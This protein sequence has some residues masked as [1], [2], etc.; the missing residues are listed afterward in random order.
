VEKG[1]EMI[2]KI[3]ITGIR[4]EV[5][6]ELKKYLTKKISKLD[7]FAP[8]QARKNISASVNL[9]ERKTKTDRNQ[10]EVIIHLPDRQITA[11]EATINMFAAVDIV[12]TKLKSQLKK[13]KATHGGDKQDH[14]GVLRR[15]FRNQRND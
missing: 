9:E 2:T 11:K 5:S 1:A 7:R 10:C 8:R 14:H 3:D 6:D 13:Y 12:E 4:Y 15:L